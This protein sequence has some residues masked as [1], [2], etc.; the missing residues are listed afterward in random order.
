MAQLKN[1]RIKFNENEQLWNLLNEQIHKAIFDEDWLKVVECTEKALSIKNDDVL[2]SN[3]Q[4]AK[5]KLM[6][7]QKE[8]SF[9]Q[10]I[11]EVKAL[12]VDKEFDEAKK[13]LSGM[14]REFAGHSAEMKIL[15]KQIFEE[16]TAKDFLKN[17]SEE[18]FFDSSMNEKKRST[19][20]NK[21]KIQNDDFFGSD[22]LENRNRKS[23]VTKDDFDF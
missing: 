23:K 14:Q 7:Q 4:I 17:K 22:Q 2:K 18:N 12:L 16:E 9:K 15:F 10:Q 1:D 8:N 20:I 21:R 5:D 6:K 19:N 13:R 11:N 3:M